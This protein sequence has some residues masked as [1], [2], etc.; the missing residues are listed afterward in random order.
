M[1]RQYQ[2]SKIRRQRQHGFRAR[3]A[4]RSGRAILNNRRRIGRRRLT[5]V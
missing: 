4:T 5:P 2:P 1:K 3:S